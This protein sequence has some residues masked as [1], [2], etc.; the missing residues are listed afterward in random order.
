MPALAEAAL[1]ARIRLRPATE[2]DAAVLLAIY[3]SSRA[4][5]MACVEWSQEQKAVFLSMQFEAQRR[6]YAAHYDGAAYMVV[7]RDGQPVGRLY[8]HEGLSD[9][10]I[11]EVQL[12]PEARGQGIG[13]ALLRG[14]LAAAAARGQRT[15]IHVELENPARRLYERLGFVPI[16]E[17]GPY[18]LMERP[19]GPPHASQSTTA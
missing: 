6:H 2:A 5:E 11:M 12:L 16:E 8:V 14:V 9:V 18:M 10:R 19:A 13:T 3:A 15:S 17:R 7:E 1:S 4:H